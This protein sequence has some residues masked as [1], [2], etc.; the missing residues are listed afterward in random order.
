MIVSKIHNTVYTILGLSPSR[1]LGYSY[2]LH[3]H[4][5]EDGIFDLHVPKARSRNYPFVS[6]GRYMILG[7]S[8]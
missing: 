5:S 6:D 1:E 8:K 7:D 2:E 4:S 3:C